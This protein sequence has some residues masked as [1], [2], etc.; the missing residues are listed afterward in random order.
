[1]LD[2]LS[3]RHGHGLT[4]WLI[5]HQF[6]DGRREVV[7]ELAGINGFERCLVHLLHRHEQAGLAMGDG[8]RNPP[9]PARDDRG[10]ASH[11]LEID[12]PERL[13]NGR[14]HEKGR[15]RV[16]RD[17]FAF[18]NHLVD[19]DHPGPL[20]LHQSDRLLHFRSN[21]RGVRR[22][23]AQHDL[24]SRIQV[25]QGVNQMDDALL[26]CDA[27]DKKNVGLRGVDAVVTQ[28]GLVGF[29]AVFL[30]IDA[31]VDHVD[32]RRIDVEKLQ[33]ILAGGFRH[34]DDRIGHLNRGPLNPD[35]KI[36]AAAELL[37][38]PR[39]QWLQRVHSEHQRQ[40]VIQFHQN[41]RQVRI[42]RVNVDE[43]RIRS[44]R[45]EGGI[46]LH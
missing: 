9:D 4:A 1:M 16:E 43:V 22:T 28:D 34:G 2:P 12:D 8:L 25:T 27:S 3:R 5:A 44:R 20:R 6:I 40:R 38:L 37:A 46:A 11:G 41:A 23:R 7:R 24:E 33:Q 35:G 14:A 18:R 21:L 45:G 13:V 19:P 32:P 42:P 31:V 17:D 26:A 36:V 29:L 15:L 10:A 30:E 39:A